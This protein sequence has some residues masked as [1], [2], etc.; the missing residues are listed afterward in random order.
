MSEYHVPVLLNDSV[1]GLNIMPN[2]VYVDVTFG[3]G[4]HSRKILESLN[5]D[6]KL[7]GFDQDSDALN[8]IPNDDRFQLIQA[9][10]RYLKNYL[11]FY[12]IEKVDGILA[13]LGVSSHQFDVAERGFSIRFDGPL[14][15]RMNTD[16]GKTAADIVNTYSEED[17]THIFSNYGEIINSKTLARTIVAG[18]NNQAVSSIED[19]KKLIMPCAPRGRE[20]KYLAQVFQSLRIEVNDELE[21]L[22]NL[23]E[24][25]VEV[26]KPG[27][28][29]V[30]IAY[31]SLE[32]RLVKNMI[33]SGN[34]EGK[35]SKDFYGNILGPFQAISRKAIIPT[36]SEIAKNSRA[37]SAKLRIAEKL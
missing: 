30:V 15:L 3:G 24:Q 32:D 8:N 11:S 4:G 22:K 17:L 23:L 20:N 5:I 10:F 18:R 36:D 34:F 28:R 2:G 1:N 33:K 19:F 26:L 25:A 14:D 37:R 35:L 9:N 31:H 16:K 6:G 29:L 7:F 21:S 13:D 27:G 12:Q